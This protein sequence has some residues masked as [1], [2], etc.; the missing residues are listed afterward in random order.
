MNRNLNKE[1]LIR[2]ALLIVL[3]VQSVQLTS[4]NAEI[5]KCTNK[6]GKVFYNDKP[7]P[8]LDDE[9]KMR[10][11]KDVVNGYIPPVL[12]EKKESLKKSNNLVSRGGLELIKQT[13]KNKKSKAESSPKIQLLAG[14]DKRKGE[15]INGEGV[16]VQHKTKTAPPIGSYVEREKTVKDIRAYLGIRRSVE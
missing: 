6:A 13:K 15:G 12:K 10:S 4:V 2:P 16:N 7:C 9:K 1:R 11:E 8:S 3:L 14:G 5:F